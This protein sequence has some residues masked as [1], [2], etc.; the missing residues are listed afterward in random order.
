[1]LKAVFSGEM[2][3]DASQARQRTY[4]EILEEYERFFSLDE[5]MIK[6]QEKSSK[7][8]GSGAVKLG[9]STTGT[10]CFLQMRIDFAESTVGG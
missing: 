6:N 3:G 7:R 8:S 4:D 1:V 2:P 5:E 9:G 10:N